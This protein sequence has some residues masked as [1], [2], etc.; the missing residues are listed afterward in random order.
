MRRTF[1][2]IGL[3]VT[4]FEIWPSTDNSS[5][6]VNVF[7]VSFSSPPL[8]L[9][10]VA[11]GVDIH[12][13]KVRNDHPMLCGRCCFE[14]IWVVCVCLHLVCETL[15]V[16]LPF[17]GYV[18]FFKRVGHMSFFWR[19]CNSHA[20]YGTRLPSPFYLVFMSFGDLIHCKFTICV[21]Y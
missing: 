17:V 21:A 1:R 11:D 3:H 13:L 15:V 12:G 16:C 5:Y 6:L 18:M 8:E 20:K 2:S 19:Q 9:A 7:I 10:H 4:L 14:R